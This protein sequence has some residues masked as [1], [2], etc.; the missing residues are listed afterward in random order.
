MKMGAVTTVL[1]LGSSTDGNGFLGYPATAPHQT[2]RHP[3]ISGYRVRRI[4]GD[5]SQK[6]LP[7]LDLRPTN[8]TVPA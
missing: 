8:T 1:V 2:V 3:R 4:I 6:I 7:D 5:V